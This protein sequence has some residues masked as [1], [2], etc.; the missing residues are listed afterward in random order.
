MQWKQKQQEILKGF[1]PLEVTTKLPMNYMDLMFQIKRHKNKK[2][3]F[4]HRLVQ[5][6]CSGTFTV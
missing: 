3:N 6:F 1:F 5:V 4:K 2:H